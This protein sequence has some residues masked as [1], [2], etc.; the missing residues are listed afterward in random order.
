MKHP[1]STT[2][3]LFVHFHEKGKFDQYSIHEKFADSGENLK[4]STVA[5]R[6]KNKLL[7][8]TVY[9]RLMMCDI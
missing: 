6:Y 3:V 9:D 5:V 4:A 7:I 1:I 8:G 2:K